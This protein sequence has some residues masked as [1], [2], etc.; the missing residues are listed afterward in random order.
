[1]TKQWFKP[2]WGGATFEDVVAILEALDIKFDGEHPVV[3]ELPHLFIP[4][5]NENVIHFEDDGGEATL[6]ATK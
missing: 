5:E 1:M 4:C 6:D 2:N 3:T